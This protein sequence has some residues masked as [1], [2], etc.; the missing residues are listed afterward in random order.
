MS[1]Y[2]NFDEIRFQYYPAA[3]WKITPLGT[4]TLRQFIESHRSPKPTIL[5]VFKEIEEAA[6]TGDLKR[7]DHLKQNNLYYFLPSCIMEGGRSYE[8]IVEFLPLMVVEFDKIDYAE[9]LKQELFGRLKSCVAAYLSPSRRGCKFII[10]IPKPKSI[11]EYKE[12]YCGLAYYLERFENFDPANF[13]ISL[14]LFLSYDENILVREDAEEWST[15]GGKLNAFKPYEGDF[16]APEDINLED[17]DEAIRIVTN[18]INRIE[19]NGHGQVVSA[20]CLIGGYVGAGYIS[21]ED[22]E[23]LLYELIGD[24]QYL[25]KGLNGYKKTAL[26]MLQKGA[27]AP[28]LL[29]RH[30]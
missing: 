2:L 11:E 8:H 17:R 12:Y 24:N 18:C 14:P 26:T 30:Q 25:S 1:N 3:V 28:L 19:D 7:K 4:L 16:N 23:E 9:E 21:M 27:S 15:R 5:N 10:R 13:N 29:N 22:A 6:F 20:S